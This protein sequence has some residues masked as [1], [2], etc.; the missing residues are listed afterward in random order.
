MQLL[1]PWRSGAVFGLV[2]TSPL[3]E[4]WVVRSNPVREYVGRQFKKAVYRN[5]GDQFL[6]RFQVQKKA[7]CKLDCRVDSIC[8]FR[9]SKVLKDFEIHF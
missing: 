7:S 6:S 3:A 4:L 8:N 9:V 1:S 5:A 2:V